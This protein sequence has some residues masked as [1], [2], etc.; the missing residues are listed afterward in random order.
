MKRILMICFAVLM[1]CQATTFANLPPIPTTEMSIGGIEIGCTFGYVKSIY[2]E[3]SEKY[4]E[5]DKRSPSRKNNLRL[6]YYYSP[7]HLHDGRSRDIIYK[8]SPTLIVHGEVGRN[9]KDSTPDDDVRVWGVSLG[10]NSL[11]TPSGLTAGIPYSTVVEAF[12]QGKKVV[13][14]GQ[15]FYMY[16]GQKPDGKFSW[17]V[18]N[19]Y[20]DSKNIIT[21]IAICPIATDSN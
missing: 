3:P 19:F 2:G 8:Y 17:N 16:V 6:I 14:E 9:E 12:G 1:L 20:V 7:N 21:R 15:T 5:D 10:D 4:Y 18:M 11:S 13:S